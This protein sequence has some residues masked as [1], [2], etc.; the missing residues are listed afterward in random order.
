METIGTE[1][2]G[3]SWSWSDRD[4]KDRDIRRRLYDENYIKV[5]KWFYDFGTHRLIHILTFEGGILKEIELGGYGGARWPSAE[6]GETKTREKEEIEDSRTLRYGTISVYGS[7][8]GARVYL[9][10]YHVGNIPCT[11]EEMEVGAYNLVIR[12]KGYADWAKRVIVEAD[13]TSFLSVYLQPAE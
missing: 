12:S 2:R 1:T 6:S 4:Y 9:D 13:R 10:E 3:R 8:Y 7:P 5:E 11:L